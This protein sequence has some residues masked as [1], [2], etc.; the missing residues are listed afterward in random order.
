MQN[1]KQKHVLFQFLK[2]SFKAYK[3]YFFSLLFSCL[4]ASATTIFSAYTFSIIIGKIEKGNYKEAIITSIILVVIEIVLAL[5]SKF[6]QKLTDVHREH[7]AEIIDQLITEKVLSLPFSYLENPY[8][9]ELKKNASMGVNNMGAVYTL[10]NS[11]V[12]ILSSLISVIGL[13]AVIMSFDVNLVYILIAGIVINIIIILFSMRYQVKFF[14][15]LLPINF[16]YGYYFDF[17]IN[18]DNCKDFRMYTTHELLESKFKM[19]NKSMSK[20]FGKRAVKDGSFQAL[21][22]TVRYIQMGAI[23]LL[24]GLKAIA[25]KLPISSFTLT[26]SSAISFSDCITKMIDASST[27]LRSI[28]YIKPVMELMSISS[29]K[30]EGKLELKSIESIKF[31][32][33]SFM[34]PNTTKLVLDDVSFEIKKEEKISIVGLNGAGKT[35]IVKLLCR[36][37]K[38]NE[39]TI[40]IN[41]ISINDYDKEKYI[42]KISAIF[43]DYKLFAYSIKDNIK[44]GISDEEVK[45][46]CD[47][48]G[49]S[50]KIEELPNKYDS[51]LL[52][53]YSSDSV[54]L[55]GG[56]RQKIAI[57][58]AIAKNADLLILDEPTSALDPLAEAEI[59]KNFNGLAK[60]RMA[61]YIS[62]R[63]SSSIF[64]DKILVLDNGKVTDFDSHEKLM[65]NEN[66]LYT[67][68]FMAQANNYKID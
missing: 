24:V 29:D 68:L 38:V 57:A 4:V 3:P 10:L 23:Y 19:Y 58:R 47:A 63:M 15:D 67:R 7:M 8:Y 37:Y 18:D 66:N 25:S 33:V 2:M 27:Y 40:L 52:K 39:G 21:M 59:Y 64:C 26:I 65:A 5:A 43:Q 45:S 14:N 49:I 46:L 41:G 55:S 53:S 28:E 56:Q 12:D 13:S 6:A 48:V 32:H 17:L 16:K 51:T 62:H 35:T 42:E 50:E 22:S 34:Y 9:M 44:E 30:E 31:D 36:L 20:Y 54:E 60:D 11:F 61:I 1:K